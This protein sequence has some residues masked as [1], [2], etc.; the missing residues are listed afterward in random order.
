M[1][2]CRPFTKFRLLAVFPAAL[3]LVDTEF[4]MPVVAAMRFVESLASG[5]LYLA[6]PCHCEVLE[7]AEKSITIREM[8]SKQKL[9]LRVPTTRVLQVAV[10]D[11]VRACQPLAYYINPEDVLGQTFETVTEAFGP[12]GYDI[13]ENYLTLTGLTGM[14]PPS[15]ARFVDVRAL[16][17]DQLAKARKLG[18]SN[19]PELYVDVGADA[20]AVCPGVASVHVD[21]VEWPVQ[22]MTDEFLHVEFAVRGRTRR[23]QTGHELLEVR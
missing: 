5:E 18:D 6:A 9:Q 22:T 12:Y 8:H 20:V 4:V 11:Q 14:T 15:G 23:Q 21:S 16:T 1:V 17:G 13:L 2:S 3:K 19:L 7:I 10:G